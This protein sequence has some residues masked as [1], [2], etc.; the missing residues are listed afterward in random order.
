MDLEFQIEVAGDE[1]LSITFIPPTKFGEEVFEKISQ[2]VNS[3]ATFALQVGSKLS[4]KNI[5]GDAKIGFSESGEGYI[6]ELTGKNVC[7]PCAVAAGIYSLENWYRTLNA[8]EE[9]TKK[10]ITADKV[11]NP[12]DVE[13]Y[14]ALVEKKA[15]EVKEN[16]QKGDMSFFEESA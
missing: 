7:H 10:K 8:L 4:R 6:L 15:K 5:H 16:C 1:S 14:C 2:S 12:A 13:M 9:T 3:I 11:L